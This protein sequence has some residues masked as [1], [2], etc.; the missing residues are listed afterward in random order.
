MQAALASPEGL[1]QLERLEALVFQDRWVIRVFQVRQDHLDSQDNLARQ[2]YQ[3]CTSPT[4][5]V[6]I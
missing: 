3:V 4:L 6:S 5:V 2:D 1:E